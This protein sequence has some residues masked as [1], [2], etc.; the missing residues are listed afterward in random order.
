MAFGEKESDTGCLEEACGAVQI[1]PTA[2][3]ALW[4]WSTLQSLQSTPTVALN[5]WY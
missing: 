5:T 3:C 1:D 2:K 4:A